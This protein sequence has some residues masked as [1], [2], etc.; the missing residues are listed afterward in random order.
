MVCEWGERGPLLMRAGELKSLR[1]KRDATNVHGGHERSQTGC[2]PSG[3]LLMGG[4]CK[5]GLRDLI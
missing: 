2:V 4:K 3:P 1:N 5:W